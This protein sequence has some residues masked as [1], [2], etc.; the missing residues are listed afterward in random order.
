VLLHF[1]L[2]VVRKATCVKKRVSKL[3]NV[4]GQNV[5]HA[6]TENQCS[7]HPV[8]GGRADDLLPVLLRY[9]LPPPP[10]PVSEQL[11]RYG[12]NLE[13][14]FKGK[15]VDQ[16]DVPLIQQAKFCLKR[17]KNL[18]LCLKKRIDLLGSMAELFLSPDLQYFE[19]Q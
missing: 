12:T 10:F 5:A 17:K 1:D 8:P 19:E 15:L 13:S 3:Q 11:I 2:G 6:T 7:G 16:V 14:G 18:K 4:P 9:P